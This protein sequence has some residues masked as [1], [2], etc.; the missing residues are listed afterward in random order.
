[1]AKTTSSTTI[2]SPIFSRLTE[3]ERYHGQASTMIDKFLAVATMNAFTRAAKDQIDLFERCLNRI[4]T[5]EGP[6]VSAAI[7]IKALESMTADITTAAASAE[8]TRGMK[9]TPTV[10]HFSDLVNIDSGNGSEGYEA[11][12]DEFKSVNG[13]SS[14]GEIEEKTDENLDVDSFHPKRMK[15]AYRSFIF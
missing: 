6:K 10:T 12:S 4:E 8:T 13:S 2:Q 1:M 3:A 14:S 11:T 15:N 5:F 7:A 9:A